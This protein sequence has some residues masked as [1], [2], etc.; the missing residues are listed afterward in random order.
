MATQQS[1]LPG[2]AIELASIPEPPQPRAR[3]R[4]DL[5]SYI[6]DVPS[7]QNNLLAQEHQIEAICCPTIT[8]EAWAVSPLRSMPPSIL[9]PT[10]QCWLCICTWFNCYPLIAA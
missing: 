8:P 4:C 10:G 3:E 1:R 6:T 2:Q 9:V 7:S 5:Y